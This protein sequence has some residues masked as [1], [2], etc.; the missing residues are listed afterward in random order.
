MSTVS[1]ELEDDL[2]V[3]LQETN[4]PL[5]EAVRELMVLELYRRAAISSGKAAEL[6][7]MD[8]F[9]FIRHASKLGIP[10]YNLSEEELLEDLAQARA[11]I[12]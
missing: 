3:L 9:D 10:F 6:L 1:L 5:A 7:N 4:R 2:T 11:S 12:A 8:R